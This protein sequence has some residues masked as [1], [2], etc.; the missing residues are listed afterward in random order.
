MK[1]ENISFLSLLRRI[2]SKKCKQS[3]YYSIYTFIASRATSEFQDMTLYL[4]VCYRLYIIAL[5]MS[6]HLD[7]L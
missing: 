3:N 4:P 6:F 1:T 5:N 2:Y 7:T